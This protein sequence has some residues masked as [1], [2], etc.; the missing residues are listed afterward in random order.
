MRKLPPLSSPAPPTGWLAA[1]ALACTLA[2]AGCTTYFNPGSG[3]P[4]GGAGP[5]IPTSTPGTSYGGNPPMSSAYSATTPMIMTA[6]RAEFR[7]KYLGRSSPAPESATV[8]TNVAVPGQPSVQVEAPALLGSDGAVNGTLTSGQLSVPF[9]IGDQANRVVFAT[10]P[11]A[12][13]PG[14]KASPTTASVAPSVTSSSFNAPAVNGRTAVTVSPV[15][16]SPTGA[17]RAATPATAASTFTLTPTMSSSAVMSPTA[18]TAV[19][20]PTNTSKAPASTTTT[21]AGAQSSGSMVVGTLTAGVRTGLPTGA[22][23]MAAA[24]L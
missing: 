1:V 24:N 18:A 2:A 5:T 7:T 22:I 15:L 10:P 14:L 9:S 12:T 20:S 16:A 21:S 23:N 3:E 8:N 4:T 6:N 17:T 11:T 13:T 19:T